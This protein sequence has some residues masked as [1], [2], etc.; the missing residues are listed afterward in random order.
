MMLPLFRIVRM[1]SARFFLAYFVAAS[2]SHIFFRFIDTLSFSINDDKLVVD[3]ESEDDDDGKKNNNN[4]AVLKWEGVRR[5]VQ[6]VWFISCSK[7]FQFMFLEVR[8]FALVS[9]SYVRCS[10][11]EVIVLPIICYNT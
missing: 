7:H 2:F 10:R 4:H 9:G 3:N 8:G 1:Y 5:Y 6:I 11:N